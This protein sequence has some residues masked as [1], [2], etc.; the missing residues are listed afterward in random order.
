MRKLLLISTIFIGCSIMSCTETNNDLMN[1]E[2]ISTKSVENY[3]D[4]TKTDSTKTNVN[5]TINNWSDTISSK[6]E[7]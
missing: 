6:H 3:A 7:F 1:E 4:T 2:T 5:V